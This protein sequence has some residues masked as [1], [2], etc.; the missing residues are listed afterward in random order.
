MG[1]KAQPPPEPEPAKE[2]PK[3]EEE[4]PI[5]ILEGDFQLSDGSTYCGEYIVRQDRHLMHGKGRLQTSPETFDG[6]F[7]EGLY[8]EGT[9]TGAD[10]SIYS[11]CF[12]QNLF[13]GPGEYT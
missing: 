6:T 1:K 8:K 9:F 13:H 5:E 4:P 7:H 12:H 2:E 11:G 3:E 10:G